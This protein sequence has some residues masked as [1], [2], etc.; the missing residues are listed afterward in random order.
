MQMLWH[1]CR[2]AKETLFSNPK[3][4]SAP[5]TVLGRGSRVIGGTIKAELPRADM[6][7]LLVDG[8]FPH[9]PLDAQ[10]QKQR[11]VGFQEI[12]LPYAADPAVSKHLAWFLARNEE[13]L[14]QSSGKKR[15]KKSKGW[16]PKR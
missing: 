9:C 7:K 3:L 13:A 2:L 14:Q 4:D 12:G 8:F 11:T 6:E 16:K 5:V 15:K 10:P 1:S